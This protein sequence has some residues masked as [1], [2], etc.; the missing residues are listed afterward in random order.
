MR[1]DIAGA[2]R[3]L[4]RR[5]P[6]NT[7]AVEGPPPLA[8][9]IPNW[10][11]AN[12]L[13]NPT[14]LRPLLDLGYRRN[15][16]V[17]VCVDEKATA[18]SGLR[19]KARAVDGKD[20]EPSHPLSA[21]LRRPNPE[22]TW[23]ELI[24]EFVTNYTAAGQAFLHKKRNAMGM[25][26][27]VWNLRPD[28]MK[29]KPSPYGI[30]S[31]TYQIDGLPDQTVSAKDIV[32][33]KR[34]N[35]LDDYFGLSPLS[36]CAQAIDL[37]SKALEYLRAFFLNGASP[38]G[39]LKLK[40]Q[41]EEPERNRIRAL[42]KR[43]YGNVRGWHDIAVID[44]EADYQELGSRPEKL[45][46]DHIWTATETR[47]CA[48]LG[49]P[50]ILVQLAVGIQ[51]STYA[52]YG[53]AVKAFWSETCAPESE[54]L[55][56]VLTKGLASEFAGG[57][58]IY[59]DLSKVEALQDSKKEYRRDL[60]DG[61]GA[62][63]VKLDEVRDAFGLEKVGPENGGDDFK[64]PAPS[65]FG[66]D[67]GGDPFGGDPDEKDLKSLRGKEKDPKG[68]KVKPKGKGSEEEAHPR[69]FGW[70]PWKRGR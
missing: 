70:K 15:M 21:L 26:V 63:F 57:P 52:N 4:F 35:P 65:P 2:T 50:P 30:E 23:R 22:Q 11:G 45:S 64:A 32:A 48:V 36:V 29:A 61:W 42:W 47:I 8:R 67:P 39:L 53:E 20:L 59:L 37:D 69:P 58:E 12:P 55:G 10:K 6:P 24:H 38:S 28:R 66:A 16:V 18:I 1:I 68:E 27:E 5:Q 3:A 33:W 62:G 25:V 46:L 13:P 51:Q 43:L 9:M 54:G 41:T 49:V 19:A 56:E 40:A 44:S 34:Y 31:Y 60:K 17:F 7:Q 14:D